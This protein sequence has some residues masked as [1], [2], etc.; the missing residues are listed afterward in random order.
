MNRHIGMA[1]VLIEANEL[2]ILHSTCAGDLAVKAVEGRR[3]TIVGQSRPY[4]LFENAVVVDSLDKDG[5]CVR[6]DR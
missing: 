6:K 5:S 1:L 2:V 3:S 4:A